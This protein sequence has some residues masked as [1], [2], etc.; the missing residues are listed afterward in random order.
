MSWNGNGITVNT[1][2]KSEKL[3]KVNSLSR[4]EIKRQRKRVRAGKRQQ[5]RKLI[6]SMTDEI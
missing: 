6:K 2:G 3:E 5:D 4:G 1:M